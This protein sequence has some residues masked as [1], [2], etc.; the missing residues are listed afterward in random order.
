M[1]KIKVGQRYQHRKAP[2]RVIEILKLRR[3]SAP[4]MNKRAKVKYVSTTDK[5]NTGVISSLLVT[6]IIALY[7]LQVP[8]EPDWEI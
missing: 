7:E 5:E 4:W 6:S 2:E 1:K 3:A 8:R